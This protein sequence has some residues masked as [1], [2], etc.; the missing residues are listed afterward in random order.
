[1]IRKLPYADWLAARLE[2]D[3]IQAQ[4]GDIPHLP[5][6]DP[7]I[8]QARNSLA[9]EASPSVAGAE[10]LLIAEQ[11]K[12]TPHLAQSAERLA[13]MII[14]FPFAEVSAEEPATNLG[15]GL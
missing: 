11:L 9:K 15:N 4:I 7:M 5:Q 10:L 6:I 3:R 14:D 12:A 13:R 1:M 8:E 2:L